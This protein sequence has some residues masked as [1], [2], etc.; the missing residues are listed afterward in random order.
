MIDWWSETDDA[1]V[2]CLRDAGPMSPEE[3]ARRIGLSVGE[4][5]AFVAM[6]VRED[7]IRIRIIELTPEEERRRHRHMPISMP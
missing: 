3:L 5:S 6:L 1:I 7:R 4:I 2:E